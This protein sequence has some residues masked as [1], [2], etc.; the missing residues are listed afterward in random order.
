L[1]TIRITYPD[2]DRNTDPDRYTGK[3]CLGGGVHCSSACS[4]GLFFQGAATDFPTPLSVSP[5][6]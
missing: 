2:P 6:P 1:L 3:T 4:S 5:K